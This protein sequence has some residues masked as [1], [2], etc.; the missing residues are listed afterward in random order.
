M[1]QTFC[2]KLIKTPCFGPIDMVTSYLNEYSKLFQKVEHNLYVDLVYKKTPVAKLKKEYQKKFGI[3]ARH[4]NSVKVSIEGK[5]KAK[6]ALL[7]DELHNKKVVLNK[8]QVKLDSLMLE[9]TTVF[10]KL[11]LLNMNDI[12]FN[13]TQTKYQSIKNSIHYTKRKIQ[14]YTHIILKLEKDFNQQIVRMCF[15]SKE[16][17]QKQFNLIE[18]GYKNHAEWYSDW[19]LFRSNQCFFLGSSDESFG[20][21]I[22][23]YD[24]NNT[25]KIKTAPIFEERYGKY[26]VIPNVYFKYGQ[27]KIDY[28]KESFAHITPSYNEKKYYN[29]ALNHRFYRTKFGWYLHTS[30]DVEEAN[31]RTDSRLGGIGLDFNVNFVSIVFVDRFANPL[32]ELKLKYCMYGKT[33]NQITAQLGELCKEVCKL[34]LYYGVPIYIENLCF[35]NAKRNI[36]KDKKYKRMINTFPYAKFRDMLIQRSMKD[37]VQIIFVNPAFTSIIGQFKFMKQY[38][39]S[40]HG[41]AACTVARKGMG[42]KTEKMHIKYKRL[43]FKNRPNLNKNTDNYK[44]WM[45]LSS[46]V[47]KNMKFNERIAMLYNS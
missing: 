39:L 10:E 35:K 5:I 40:S 11:S 37:G 8:L 20:N 31:I 17:F 1:Q 13:K 34:G 30:A 42:C 12:R 3:N 33:S 22:C 38:G 19:Q 43:V 2:T 47:K 23:Q 9:K 7:E 44:M 15:G 41:S 14:K 6:K 4:F 28:C 29:G 32:D 25:L 18:N 21:Q 26:I 45:H 27:E 46:I 24:K 16:F 36:D